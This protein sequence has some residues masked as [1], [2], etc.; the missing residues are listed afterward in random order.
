M[1]KT[2][3]NQAQ[4]IV[5]LERMVTMLFLKLKKLEDIN[6]IKNESRDKNIK[7]IIGLKAKKDIIVQFCIMSNY[8]KTTF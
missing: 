4:R 7:I 6:K 1:R 8:L 2:K 5:N 3:L